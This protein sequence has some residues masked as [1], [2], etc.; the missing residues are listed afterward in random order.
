M[1]TVAVRFRLGTI[2]AA[3]IVAGIV[4]AAFEML[5]A[6]ML[7]GPDA[8]AMPLRMIGAMVLGEQALDPG[9]SLMTA[10]MTGVVVH[11]ILS[12]VFTGIFAAIA[13]PM[14]AATGLG[15]TNGTL[16][17][18]GTAFGIVLWLVNFYVVAPAAGWTWFPERTDPVV[19]FLA[20]AFFFGCTAGWMLGRGRLRGIPTL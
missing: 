6:A 11:L 18:A 10:A 1:A 14:L 19:Q 8:A 16:A 5:A 20:H 17:V 15:T 4:F 3:G 13:A 7:M 12:I 9:Y 2:V